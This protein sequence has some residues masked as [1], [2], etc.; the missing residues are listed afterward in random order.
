LLYFS[1][2]SRIFVKGIA[3]L[4]LSDSVQCDLVTSVETLIELV[5]VLLPDHQVR[6]PLLGPND[7]LWPGNGLGILARSL[8]KEIEEDR[9][10]CEG[11]H[12]VKLPRSRGLCMKVTRE[13]LLGLLPALL[14]E[15]DVPQAALVVVD[16]M[17]DLSAYL[18]KI[19]LDQLRIDHGF[20]RLLTLLYRIALLDDVV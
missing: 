12:I 7:C 2:S 14:I 6:G 17:R 16:L 3:Y 5:K 13:V 4:T 19:S 8:L 18:A 20:H 15:Q 9:V 10:M 1:W 11:F